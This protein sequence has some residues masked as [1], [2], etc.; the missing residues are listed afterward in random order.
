M[1]YLSTPV[2]NPLGGITR[3]K[4]T[5]GFNPSPV[6][7]GV[8]LPGFVYSGP[9]THDPSFHIFLMEAGVMTFVGHC[10]GEVHDPMCTPRHK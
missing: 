5:L 9:Q 4:D 7:V 2:H 10:T 6:W 8:T 1:V 3:G